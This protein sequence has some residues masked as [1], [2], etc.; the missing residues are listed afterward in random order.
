MNQALQRYKNYCE[1]VYP[2]N[3]LWVFKSFNKEN[4]TITKDFSG[5]IFY[6][7][8]P[9]ASRDKHIRSCKNKDNRLWVKHYFLS[10][11]THTR[12]AVL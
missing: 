2:K 4:A 5:N 7:G 6:F 3:S 10:C 8:M 1:Q 11:S 9:D 12:S